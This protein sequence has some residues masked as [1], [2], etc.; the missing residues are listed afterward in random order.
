MGRRAIL[1]GFEFDCRRTIAAKGCCQVLSFSGINAMRKLISCLSVAAV[2][3][4]VSAGCRPKPVFDESEVESFRPQL[5]PVEE[6]ETIGEMR[7]WTPASGGKQ[8]EGALIKV[9]DGKIFI[10]KKDGHIFGVPPN[11]LSD[12]DQNYARQAA[13]A[14]R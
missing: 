6:V 7:T 12:E 9:E 4:G 14:A 11:R 1:E 2:I 8:F 10:K 5:D 3:L 13:A